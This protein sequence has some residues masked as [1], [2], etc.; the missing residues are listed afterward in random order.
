MDKPMVFIKALECYSTSTFDFVDTMLWAYH[1]VEQQE[2]FTFDDKLN[3]H[4]RRA[5]KRI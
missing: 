4:I 2:V 1:V 5:G 3:K